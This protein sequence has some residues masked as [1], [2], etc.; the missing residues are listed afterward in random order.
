M[1]ESLD[2]MLNDV[3]VATGHEPAIDEDGWQVFDPAAAEPVIPGTDVE[4]VN[5]KVG[6]KSVCILVPQK[7]SSFFLSSGC[8]PGLET[9]SGHGGGH[10]A[11]IVES[12]RGLEE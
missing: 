1:T 12:I 9:H 4:Q 11:S 2:Q 7:I 3:A 5:V 8:R 10:Y 6:R